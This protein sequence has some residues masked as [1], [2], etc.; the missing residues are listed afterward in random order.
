MSRNAQTAVA[1]LATSMPYETAVAGVHVAAV[2]RHA[3]ELGLIDPVTDVRAGAEALAKHSA[4]AGFTDASTCRIW[5][6]GEL[7]AITELTAGVDV[8][9]Q[10]GRPDGYALGNLYQALSVESRKGRA[11][12]QT[13]RF[14]TELLLDCTIPHAIDEWGLNALR[15]IDPACGTGHILI[16]SLIR[17]WLEMGGPHD[18]TPFAT[19]RIGRALRAVRGVD[20]DPYA[21]LIARYR[22]LALAC[23]LDGGQAT[24]ANAPDHWAPQVAAADSL[25]ADDEPLLTRGRYHVV[26]GNPPYITVKDAKANAAIRAAYPR[27]CSGKYSL[28]LPFF[29]LMTDLAVPG[30]WIAQLTANSFMKREFGKKFI[31]GY[32]PGYDLRWVI[33]TS[34]AYIPG[35]GTPTVILVHRSQPPSSPTVATVMGVRGEPSQPADPAQ[36]L[37]WSAIREA[38]HRHE[39]AA[40]FT[41][42]MHRVQPPGAIPDVDMAE[43]PGRPQY[44]QPSLLDLLEAA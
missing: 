38:V 34:G 5:S 7:P 26:V 13:P 36:G 14:V 18:S 21:A 37:V 17:T 4:L 10:P 44:S 11:L 35:H 33:D 6:A 19:D 12:C 1:R 2:I 42:A 27:V 9:D 24:L 23:R 39:S 3:T 41:S 15:M 16:E 8:A 43:P 40:R 20:L 28:A 32:L 25:L 29:Q 22:L 31:E 30:G